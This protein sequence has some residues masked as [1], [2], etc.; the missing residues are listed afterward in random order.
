MAIAGIILLLLGFLLFIGTWLIICRRQPSRLYAL[1]QVVLKHQRR[2]NP[3]KPAWARTKII[4]LKTQGPDLGCRT[5]ALII[6]LRH[7][8]RG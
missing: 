4:R 3:P 2:F 6:S 5:I 8:P 7:V 1:R